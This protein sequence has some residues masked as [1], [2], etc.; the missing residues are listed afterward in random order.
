MIRILI[1]ALA[2]VA[3]PQDLLEA[4]HA[5]ISCAV[6]L[7]Q[8]GEGATTVLD[9]SVARISSGLDGCWSVQ[10]IRDMRDSITRIC[11]SFNKNS[12]AISVRTQGLFSQMC[13]Y[14]LQLIALAVENG[15]SARVEQARL[16]QSLYEA[17][18]GHAEPR[19]D[20]V[21]ITTGDS[22]AI[23]RW[24]ERILS[25][26][27]TLSVRLDS[28]TTVLTCPPKTTTSVVVTS[29]VDVSPSPAW[30]KTVAD[31]PTTPPLP[32]PTRIRILWGLFSLERPSKTVTNPL[33]E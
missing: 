17:L 32:P 25:E 8:T 31:T 27:K 29:M 16:T 15:Q 21:F 28:L 12:T 13:T 14:S 7:Q 11:P 5:P 20:T 24:V 19:S 9:S 30:C 6:S 22:A 33:R 10:R 1:A 4:Q 3:F 18:K 26:V 23:E 2:L